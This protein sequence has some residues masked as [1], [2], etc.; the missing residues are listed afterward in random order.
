[1]PKYRL[2][3]HRKAEKTLETLDEKIKRHLLEEIG[4]LADFTGLKTNLDIAKMQGQKHFYRLRTQKLRTVF[5]VD[6]K[7][8]TII[9]LKIEKRENV[10]E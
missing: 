6:Q 5:C 3:F 2:T 9:I 10:Y 8:K 4:G 7:S 1:M